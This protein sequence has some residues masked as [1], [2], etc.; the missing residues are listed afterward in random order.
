MANRPRAIQ[1]RRHRPRPKMPRPER[2]RV[3]RDPSEQLAAAGDRMVGSDQHHFTAAQRI[4]V[5]YTE[6]TASACGDSLVGKYKVINRNIPAFRGPVRRVRFGVQV[7]RCGLMEQGMPFLK[8]ILNDLVSI[9]KPYGAPASFNVRH[10][11][12]ARKRRGV[13]E[14]RP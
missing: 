1:S 8:E 6:G 5:R 3:L 9:E 12:N 10:Y 14:K 11:F 7:F 13:R 4:R 2:A